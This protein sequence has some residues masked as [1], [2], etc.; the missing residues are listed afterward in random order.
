MVEV[1]RVSLCKIRDLCLEYCKKKGMKG[2]RIEIHYTTALDK[3]KANVQGFQKEYDILISG[4]LKG[5][6][7]IEAIAHELAHIVLQTNAHSEEFEKEKDEIKKW[8]NE[9]LQNK[10]K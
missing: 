7:F 10:G 2:L 5:E 8:L 3:V 6:K 4:K 1:V 9:K